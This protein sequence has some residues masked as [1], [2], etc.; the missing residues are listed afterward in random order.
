MFPIWKMIT[1]GSRESFKDHGEFY[2]YP[3]IHEKPTMF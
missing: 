1:K 3:K 2:N